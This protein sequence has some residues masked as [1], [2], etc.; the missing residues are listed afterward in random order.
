MKSSIL[1]AYLL[2]LLVRASPVEQPRSLTSIQERSYS[3]DLAHGNYR[4]IDGEVYR[5]RQV[6]DGQFSGIKPDE[7]DDEVHV[8]RDTELAANLDQRYDAHNTDL[9]VRGTYTWTDYCKWGLY[10]AATAS[11]SLT[12]AVKSI[13]GTASDPEKVFALFRGA[14]DKAKAAGKATFDT[15]DRPFLANMVGVGAQN[16]LVVLWTRKSS[17][18]AS[19]QPAMC[20]DASS[21][22][23]VIIQMMQAACAQKPGSGSFSSTLI[24]NGVTFELNMAASGGDSIPDSAYCK[25]P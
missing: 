17:S 7:W 19:T 4:R 8:K 12:S 1:I 23:A 25:K 13:P 10:C 6:G 9:L 18:S 5:L 3:D 22:E 24:M 20:T 16:I 2:P 14:Y 21:E 11:L 15:L